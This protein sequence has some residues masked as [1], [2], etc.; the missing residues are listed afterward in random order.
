MLRWAVK[1]EIERL[2]PVVDILTD[3]WLASEIEHR[4]GKIQAPRLGPEEHHRV[5][6][7]HARVVDTRPA[8]ATQPVV[9]DPRAEEE[10][11]HVVR[12][13]KQRTWYVASPAPDRLERCPACGKPHPAIIEWTMSEVLMLDGGPKTST[14]SRLLVICKEG[15]R[16]SVHE[17]DPGRDE[18][19][20]L[21]GWHNGSITLD[22]D[23]KTLVYK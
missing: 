10:R 14:T 19:S 15:P 4:L 21:T 7:H 22:A 13:G 17:L 9:P 3:E 6:Y 1:H 12:D 20:L 23:G 2:R 5:E 8:G 11:W 18:T 16:P